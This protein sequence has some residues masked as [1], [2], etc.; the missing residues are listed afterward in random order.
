MNKQTKRLTND[1]NYKK[2][3]QKQMSP[4]EIK[5]K[6]Q[7]YKPIDDINTVPLNSHIRYFTVDKN[8]GKKQFRLGGFLTKIEDKYIVL[9][10]GKLSWSVQKDSSILFQKMNMTDIKDEI[11]QKVTNK[12]EK[13]IKELMAENDKLKDTLKEVRRTL[14]KK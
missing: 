13:K 14:K 6:L 7:E 3:I 12:Y 10:N 2:S 8:T 1:T 9:S 11:I 4:D 5:E